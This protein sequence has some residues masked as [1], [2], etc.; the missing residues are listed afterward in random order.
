M[1][2]RSTAATWV[3][4]RIRTTIS[5][6]STRSSS[7]SCRSRPASL[8]ASATFDPELGSSAQARAARSP[9]PPSPCGR[10]PSAGAR[11][12]CGCR[13][14]LD[15]CRQ[16]L[17]AVEQAPADRVGRRDELGR[18][19]E[20]PGQ[21]Q[22]L[23][24]GLVALREAAVLAAVDL[25]VGVAEAVD[26]LELVADQE[27]PGRPARAAARSAAAAGRSC[28][29]TRRPSDGRT[30][31]GSGPAGRP[32]RL[33]SSTAFSWRSSKSSAARSSLSRS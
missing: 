21:R 29:G 5:A 19:A 20:V 8:R 25:D 17:E 1:S 32:S 30:A 14:F 23:P 28:P 13:L 26:R 4:A 9:R 6:G 31:R 27:E 16:R 12:R 11:R 24:V 7:T 18:R 15:E 10:R 33:S 3:K 2:A 22:R